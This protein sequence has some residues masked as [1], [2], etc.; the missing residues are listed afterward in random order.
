MRVNLNFDRPT[1]TPDEIWDRLLGQF[2]F[3]VAFFTPNPSE[4][5]KRAARPLL[6][7]G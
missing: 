2:W 5:P 6:P 7:P 1:G 4:G 3:K